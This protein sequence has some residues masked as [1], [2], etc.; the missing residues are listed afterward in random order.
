LFVRKV[1][2]SKTKLLALISGW[3]VRKSLNLLD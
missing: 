2:I 3:R 1:K